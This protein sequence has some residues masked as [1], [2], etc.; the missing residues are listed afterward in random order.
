MTDI[1]SH[2]IY[3]VDDGSRSIEESIEILQKLKQIGFD[4]VIITPHFIENSEYS[5]RNSEKEEKLLDIKNLL[6]SNDIDIN[7]YIG[8]EIFINEDIKNL[9]EKGFVETL[10][11]TNYLLIELP[12]H[13]KILNLEDVL[14]ELKH[15]GY[16]PIIAHPERYS[17]FQENYKLVDELKEDGILFQSNYASIIGYYGKEAEKLLKYMLKHK[18]VDYLGTDIHR[19]DKI[20]VIDN[21]KKIEKLFNKI[22]G[23][24]Y[25][26]QIKDNCDFLVK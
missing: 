10:A 24:D 23:K 21:F 22:A 1:H 20:C 13:N 16:V 4:N 3:G 6:K 7:I 2:L 9:I 5:S 17:Y 11:G 8:N 15:K 25:Y 14:Y 26:K 19:I 12:F 18:Y